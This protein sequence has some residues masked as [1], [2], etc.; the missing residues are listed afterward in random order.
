MHAAGRRLTTLTLDNLADLSLPCRSCVSWELDP[1]AAQRAGDAG[2]AA[3]EKEAWISAVLLEWGN[4][5][6][7]A[8]VGDTPVGFVLYAPPGLVPRAATFPTSPVSADAV[9]LVT[10]RV[11]PERQ[12]AGIGR[13]LVHAAARDLVHRGVRAIEAFGDARWESPA[14]V[15]PADYLSE[16]GFQIVRAHHRWPRLR[17]DL[18]TAGT[19]REEVEVAVERI[20]GSVVHEPAL[21]PV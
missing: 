4:C 7:L 19:W 16:I 12:G 15:L 14:C 18:R 2:D 17:L 20:I 13:A 5:G 10:A 21:R 11:R 9:L 3:L 1:L 6:I 8:Y